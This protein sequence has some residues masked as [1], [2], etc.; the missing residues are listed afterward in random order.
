MVLN[1]ASETFLPLTLS[2][3]LCSMHIHR[4]RYRIDRR[5]EGPDFCSPFLCYLRNS[6][7]WRSWVARFH[8]AV[9]LLHH[10]LFHPGGLS[11]YSPCFHSVFP[12]FRRGL[13]WKIS[14]AMMLIRK[15][16]LETGCLDGRILKSRENMAFLPGSCFFE[17]FDHSKEKRNY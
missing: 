4:G 9:C 14:V 11:L 1:V 16:S 10:F 17:V 6:T 8:P 5:E 2:C 7:R 15:S 13:I 3:F 12:C